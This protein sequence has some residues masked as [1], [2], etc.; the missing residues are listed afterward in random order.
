MDEMVDQIVAASGVARPAAR[1]AAGIIIGFLSNQGPPAAVE[2]LLDALP[3]SRDLAA[4]AGGGKGG[5]MAVFGDFTRAGLGIGDIRAV[6]GAF[7]DYANA[8]AGRAKVD[9]VITAIPSLAQFV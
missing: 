3:G 2:A 9:A 8:K 5:L 4:E 7:L 6:A 1:R